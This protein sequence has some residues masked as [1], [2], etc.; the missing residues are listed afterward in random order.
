MPSE[1]IDPLFCSHE[2]TTLSDGICAS[3]EPPYGIDDFW[4]H[5]VCDDCDAIV[6][7]GEGENH[8]ARRRL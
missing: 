1:P 3:A 2:H 6:A 5:I 7:E 8:P 4:W